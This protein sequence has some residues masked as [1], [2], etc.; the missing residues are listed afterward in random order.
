MYPP[1][2]IAKLSIKNAEIIATAYAVTDNINDKF[3]DYITEHLKSN[4]G[5]IHKDWHISGDIFCP[6]NWPKDSS[7]KYQA[8]YQLSWW[9]EDSWWFSHAAGIEGRGLGLALIM[10]KLMKQHCDAPKDTTFYRQNL[11]SIA[12]AQLISCFNTK[13]RYIVFPFTPVSLRNIAASYPDWDDAMAEV[14]DDA[15]NRLIDAHST[16]DR[17]VRKLGK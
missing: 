10:D 12:G 1:N 17:F 7:Q 8:Y 9:G 14:I 16:I 3:H 6:K 4:I 11:Q 15:F 2:N 5:N 13:N